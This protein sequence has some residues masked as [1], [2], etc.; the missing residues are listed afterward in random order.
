MAYANM[1]G[2]CRAEQK[3]MPFFGTVNE[4]AFRKKIPNHRNIYK[5]CNAA[6]WIFFSMKRARW[7]SRVLDFFQDSRIRVKDLKPDIRLFEGIPEMAHYSLPMG[8][9]AMMTIT[10]SRCEN[11]PFYCKRRQKNGP[12]WHLCVYSNTWP[13]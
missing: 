6:L 7:R 10:W 13:F 1:S 4:R 8:H 11:G 9:F 5:W 12:Y 2:R 3:Y